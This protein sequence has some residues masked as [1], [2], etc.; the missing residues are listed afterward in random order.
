MLGDYL[1]IKS[2]FIINVGCEFE[3]V[4]QNGYSKH[5]VLYNAIQAVKSFMAI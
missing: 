2:A 4:C 5:T 1:V 3:I